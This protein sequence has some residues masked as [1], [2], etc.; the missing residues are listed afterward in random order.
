MANITSP[1][2]KRTSNGTNFNT[3]ST[4]THSRFTGAVKH[5]D[6]ALIRAVNG[7]TASFSSEIN[8]FKNDPVGNITDILYGPQKAI[9]KWLATDTTTTPPGKRI[10]R[11]QQN[12]YTG[13]VSAKSKLDGSASNK[14]VIPIQIDPDSTYSWNLPPHKWSLPVDPSAIVDTVNT[15][16]SDL[17]SLRRGRIFVGR[18]YNGYTTTVDPKT[19]K[20]TP[21]GDGHFNNNYGFQFLWNPETFSQNTS[22][23]WGITPDQNDITALLTGLVASNSSI[24]LTIRIDRSNDFACAKASYIARGKDLDLAYKK[25]GSFTEYYREGQAPNSGADFAANIKYKIDDLLTRGTE[26]DLEFL[27]RTINGDGYSLLGVN[28]S[29]ISFLRPTIVRVDLGPQRLVGMIQSV[30]VS[31]LAFTRDMIPI[32]TDVMLSVDLRTA[33]SLSTNNFGGTTEQLKAA[34]IGTGG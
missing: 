17:H 18:K 19:G 22:V 10:T 15:Y 34:G 5:F 1:A 27:Y 11:I 3:I 28:T 4:P 23:N 9:I 32:R 6:N 33:A 20:K 21:T 24:N 29:N 13:G 25:A 16:S 31:H 12:Q 26:A 30:D 2:S 14:P 7:V 8:S